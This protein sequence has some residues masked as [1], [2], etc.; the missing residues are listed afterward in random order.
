MTTFL[1]HSFRFYKTSPYIYI[2]KNHWQNFGAP[3][4]PSG[5]DGGICP[6]PYVRHALLPTGKK[7]DKKAPH[8]AKQF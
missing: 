6:P 3:P 1:F 8:I 2:L 7:C 5:G 4:P